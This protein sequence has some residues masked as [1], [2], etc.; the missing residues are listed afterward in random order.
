MVRWAYVNW[1]KVMPGKVRYVTVRN[2]KLKHPTINYTPTVI[3][4]G[5]GLECSG[6]VLLGIGK[7]WYGTTT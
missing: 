5:Y 6:L 7:V 4:D 2:I 3:R 1:D